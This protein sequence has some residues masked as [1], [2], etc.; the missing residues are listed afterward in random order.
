[1][2]NPIAIDWRKKLQ[3]RDCSQHE[4]ENLDALRDVFKLRKEISITLVAE[5][6]FDQKEYNNLMDAFEHTNKLIKQYLFLD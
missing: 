4:F 5:W 2:E 3:I 1:M 6:W